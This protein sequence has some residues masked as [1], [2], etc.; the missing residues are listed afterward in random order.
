L[1]MRREHLA[2]SAGR[3]QVSGGVAEAGLAWDTRAPD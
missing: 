2:E 1:K 3:R